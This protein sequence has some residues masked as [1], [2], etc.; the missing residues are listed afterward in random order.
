VCYNKSTIKINM[1][2]P[3]KDE[4]KEMAIDTINEK[5]SSG[6]IM[7]SERDIELDKEYNRLLCTE[8]TCVE[9]AMDDSSGEDEDE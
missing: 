1:S 8:P 3:T 7:P 5:I 4:L 2:Y 9:E 6:E